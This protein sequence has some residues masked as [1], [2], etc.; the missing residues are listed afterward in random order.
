MIKVSKIFPNLWIVKLKKTKCGAQ[1][2]VALCLPL[3]TRLPL[4]LGGIHLV[5]YLVATT[6][7]AG[8]RDQAPSPGAPTASQSLATHTVI[9]GTNTHLYFFPF[10]KW[11][12]FLQT[13]FE[14]RFLTHGINLN[15]LFC[16]IS[17][18]TRRRRH[19]NVFWAMR[20]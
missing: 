7:W 6:R 4:F 20:S 12:Y 14:A 15:S 18:W 9:I 19:I 8:R 3:N 17:D 11:C 1:E 16:I 10:G 2:Q 5:K 13:L